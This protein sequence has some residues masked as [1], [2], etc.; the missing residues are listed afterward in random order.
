[1][2]DVVGRRYWYLLF[3]ALIIVPGIISLLIPPSLKPGIEFTSGS[4]MTLRFQ[5]VVEQGQVREEMAKLGYS[6]AAI[7]HTREGTF[8]VRTRALKE[9]EKDSEGNV[10]AP[11]EKDLIV[12]ALSERFD[13]LEVLSYDTVSP[14]VAAEIVR[15]AAVAVAFASVGILLYITWAFRRLPRPFRYGTCAVIA[16][17]HDVLVVLGLFSIFGKLFGIEIDSM[18]ITAVL[19]VIGYSVHDTIVVFDRIRENLRKATR[20][21]FGSV[22]NDS[23]L[24][25][26]GRSINTTMTLL[27]TIVALLLFG[28][29]TIRNFLLVLLIGVTSGAYSSIF[30][31]SQLLVIW[32]RGELVPLMQKLRPI[33]T[34]ARSRG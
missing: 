13:G 5:E 23:I 3:S 7:Q 18:F 27:F 1:M 8:L 21:E 22:V 14:L 33:L 12:K 6:D 16:L 32:E 26:L 34:L 17:I 9:E 24:Q 30:N 31:A 15:N 2:L 25:T 20:A 11:S 29:V 10:V 28:G 4:V 19:T